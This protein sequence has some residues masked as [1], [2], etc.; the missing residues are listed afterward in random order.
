MR[1]VRFLSSHSACAPRRQRIPPPEHAQAQPEPPLDPNR[2]DHKKDNGGAGNFLR[3]TLSGFQRKGSAGSAGGG[4]NGSVHSSTNG[5]SHRINGSMGGRRPSGGR[6]PADGR[7]PGRRD[8][9]AVARM[10][11]EAEARKKAEEEEPEGVDRSWQLP[12]NVDY[13][14]APGAW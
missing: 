8:P 12:T 10:E 1:V 9:E 2:A 3:R 4:S 14:T 6:R 13:Y 11:A 5:D 7:A